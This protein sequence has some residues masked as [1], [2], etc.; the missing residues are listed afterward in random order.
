MLQFGDDTY[1]E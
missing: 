1:D